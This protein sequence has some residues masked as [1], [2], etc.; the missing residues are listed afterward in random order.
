LIA[1]GFMS[2]LFATS[3]FDDNIKVDI[4]YLIISLIF[5]GLTIIFYI[6]NRLLEH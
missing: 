2:V 5:F 4:G 3:F 6:F 1:G